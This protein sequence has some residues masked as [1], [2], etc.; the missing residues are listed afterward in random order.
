MAKFNPPFASLG[1][2]NRSPTI[3]EQAGGFTC[4]P[5]DL[6]LF[7]RL[8]GRIE[9]E[10]KAIQTA[11]GITG[12]ET[13]DTT[14]LQ[15]IQALISAATGGGDV[16]NFVLFAQAQSRLPIFPEVQTSDGRLTVTSPSTGTVRI[17]AGATI[18]HRGIRPYTTSLTNLSTVASKTY[19]LRWSPAGG[20]VLKDLSDLTYNP[21]T[22]AETNVA[23][24]SSYDDMLVA[25]VVTNSSN[26]VSITNLANKADLKSTGEVLQ[27]NTTWQNDAV[28][29][30]MTALDGAIVNINWARRPIAFLTGFTDVTVQFGSAAVIKEVNVVVQSLS[31][32][33][34]K[35]IYQRTTDPSGAYVAWAA[36]A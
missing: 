2:V 13:D 16:S 9:A 5:L 34:L 30:T 19:H 33:Q 3:D 17:A 4:G 20:F 24:D 14:V 21:T 8:F 26:V 31:R 15:A 28:P 32:Y 10:L 25:R 11:G 6:T 7:N 1:G 29:S 27:E 22:A 36:T 23:F 35:A 12:T 18:L